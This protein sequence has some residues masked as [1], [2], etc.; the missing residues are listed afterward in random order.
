MQCRHVQ[1]MDIVMAHQ[2]NNNKI[3]N[4]SSAECVFQS[5]IVE[6]I[7]GGDSYIGLCVY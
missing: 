3:G 1:G 4:Y 6:K 2:I 7:V 5:C